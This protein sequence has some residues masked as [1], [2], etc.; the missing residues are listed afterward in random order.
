MSQT[1]LPAELRQR[2]RARAG[3]CCE[4]CRLPQTYSFA[5]HQVD[6]KHCR[7]MKRLFDLV[8]VLGWAPFWLPLLLVLAVLVRVRVGVPVF[9]LQH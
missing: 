2:V 4:Y 3:G 8:L 5:V 7:T 9:F 1:R 6:H